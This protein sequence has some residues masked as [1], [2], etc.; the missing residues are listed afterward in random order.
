MVP[1]LLPDRAH[2]PSGCRCGRRNLIIPNPS[3]PPQGSLCMALTHYTIREPHAAS[4]GLVVRLDC[5]GLLPSG[6]RGG[7]WSRARGEAADRAM[8]ASL[9]DKL[10][11]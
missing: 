7:L 1:G 6:C 8:A 11:R 10:G 2:P 5:H 9:A 3:E 4:W